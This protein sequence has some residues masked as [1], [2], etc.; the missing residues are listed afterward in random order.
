MGRSKKSWVPKKSELH[1][2]RENGIFEK[3]APTSKIMT[4][5]LIIIKIIRMIVIV[6]I[7]IVIIMMIIMIII[8][9]VIISISQSQY[10]RSRSRYPQIR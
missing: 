3:F 5:I 4:I 10:P 2:I 1:D 6:T 9:I 7:I 8:M